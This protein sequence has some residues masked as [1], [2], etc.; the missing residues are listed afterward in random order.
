MEINNDGNL[1]NG[2]TGNKTKLSKFLNSEVFLFFKDLMIIAI[3]VL[4]IRLY[5][6]MPF[7]ISWQSMYSSYYDKE[8]I[9]VDRISYKFWNPKRWDVI[10]FRP[11]VNENKEYF[12]KRIIWIPGDK[13]K[14]EN[15]EVFI[16]AKWK[17]EFVKLE[18][19][20]LNSENKWKTFVGLDDKA[21][22]YELSDDEYFTI[23]DNRNHSTDSR[24]CF[25][26][27]INRKEF[28]SKSDIIW[29][30][31][32]DLWYFNLSKL[33]FINPWLWIETKPKFFNSEASYDYPELN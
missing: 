20:Y 4:V 21:H 14:I 17:T 13:L 3:I 30:V 18:E 16:Q 26:D 1:E 9:I 5:V 7:Q 8:F 31:F 2:V 28:V 33:K 29:K 12:L 24:E 10:V 27:C 15:G 22:I 19:P 32:L 23:W 6:V 11:H 25:W